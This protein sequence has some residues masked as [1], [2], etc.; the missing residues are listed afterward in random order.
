MKRLAVLSIFILICAGCSKP[1][2]H[3]LS[4]QVIITRPGE[5]GVLNILTTYVEF[6]NHQQLVMLGE[7]K[8]SIFL[9]PGAVTFFVHSAD[10]NDPYSD[11]NTMSW[12]SNKITIDLKPNQ[13]VHYILDVSDHQQWV[14]KSEE[15]K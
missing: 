1:E 6:S 7:Q 13:V 8:A 15:E 14:L 4:C 9:S 3:T 12:C 10:G 11:T 2:L 5:E